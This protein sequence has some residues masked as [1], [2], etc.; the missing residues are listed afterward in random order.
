M[1]ASSGDDGTEVTFSLNFSFF[2]FILVEQFSFFVFSLTEVVM[3]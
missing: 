1:I 2:S 3:R